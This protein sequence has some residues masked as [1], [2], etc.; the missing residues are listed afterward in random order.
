MQARESLASALI[1]GRRHFGVDLAV[2]HKEL[3][4]GIQSLPKSY[5]FP[6]S[7][8]DNFNTCHLP[9]MLNNYV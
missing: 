7:P 9:L 5:S 2:R 8:P 6:L 4:A 1:D 3:S